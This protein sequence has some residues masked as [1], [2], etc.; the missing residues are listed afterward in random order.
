MNQKGLQNTA[1]CKIEL[2]GTCGSNF[3]APLLMAMI[4][5]PVSLVLV[6]DGARKRSNSTVNCQTH[7]H[8]DECS[9]DR[10]N[11][12][13]EMMTSVLRSQHSEVSTQ[14]GDAAATD[15]IVLGVELT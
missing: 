10:C 13:V 1:A 5:S 4:T 7:I 12:G 3:V 8:S 14:T 11:A 6:I 2:F 15:G 9:W